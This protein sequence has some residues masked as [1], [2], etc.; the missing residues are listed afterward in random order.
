MRGVGDGDDWSDCSDAGHSNA[1]EYPEIL[2]KYQDFSRLT[3]A[4]VLR[5][6]RCGGRD[7]KYKP[8]ARVPTDTDSLL[9]LN[10][11]HKVY[12]F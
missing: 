8:L 5:L 10:I 12:Y 6:P 9:Y 1:T 3:L 11:E 4:Q 2:R 7:Q